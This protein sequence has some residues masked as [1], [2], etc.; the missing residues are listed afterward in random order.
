M[1]IRKIACKKHTK[2]RTRNSASQFLFWRNYRRYCIISTRF[3]SE[4]STSSPK[5]TNSGVCCNES[6]NVKIPAWIVQWADGEEHTGQRKCQIVQYQQVLDVS[7]LWRKQ[8]ST[9]VKRI[10]PYAGLRISSLHNNRNHERAATGSR[11]FGSRL[12]CHNYT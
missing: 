11:E 2:K 7:H 8:I 9:K 3:W 1:E 12:L 5:S 4:F 10:L 6:T